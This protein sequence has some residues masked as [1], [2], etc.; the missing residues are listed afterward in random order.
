MRVSFH[1]HLRHSELLNK[2]LKGGSVAWLSF[3]RRRGSACAAAAA[4][5]AQESQRLTTL[6]QAGAV[7]SRRALHTPASL[8]SIHYRG[9]FEE[10]VSGGEGGGDARSLVAYCFSV[11]DDFR[12]GSAQRALTQAYAVP[13]RIFFSEVV[14]MR[15]RCDAVPTWPSEIVDRLGN[16]EP[17]SSL[18]DDTA[19]A[20]R[21]DVVGDLHSSPGGSGLG[22]ASLPVAG[23]GFVGRDG[24]AAESES[25]GDVF[26][27]RDGSL[28]LWGIDA[29][30]EHALLTLLETFRPLQSDEASLSSVKEEVGSRAGTDR[31]VPVD[32]VV[33]VS[34][35]TLQVR[36]YFP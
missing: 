32:A 25:Y 28:V 21:N 2:T 1:H 4:T 13:S 36:H 22:S 6:Q 10:F 20:G 16:E 17:P 12:F 9:S 23:Q 8:R 7:A 26:L 5:F 27:F 15:V 33:G 35:E 19:T 18:D 3:A 34:R 31:R 30:A 29:H 14:H 24:E 11:S